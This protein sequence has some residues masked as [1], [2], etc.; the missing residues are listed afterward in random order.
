[1]FSL[2]TTH[3]PTRWFTQRVI[4]GLDETFDRESRLRRKNEVIGA[5]CSSIYF[6]GDKRVVTLTQP[7]WSFDY[8]SSVTVNP[9][10]SINSVTSV[11]IQ[12]YNKQRLTTES[13][14]RGFATSPL[15]TVGA[16]GQTDASEEWLENTTLGVYAQQQ[17]GWRGRVYVTGAV[18]ADDSSAFGDDFSWAIYPKFSA[19]WVMHEEPFWGLDWVSQFRLRGAWGAAG[20]QPDLIAASRL[21][22]P[23]TGTGGTPAV[24][25]LSFGNPDLGPERGEELELG[26]DAEFLDGR[27]SATF[28]RYW[29]STKDGILATPLPP[30][31]GFTSA[32]S[33]DVGGSEYFVNLGEVSGWGTETTVS[34]VAMA[35]DPLRWDVNFSFTT[36]GNEIKSLGDVDQIPVPRG[37]DHVVGYQLA[38]LFEKKVLRAEF[39]SG[40]SGAVTNL[41]CDGGVEVSG[42]ALPMQGGSAVPCDEAPEVFWGVGEPTRLASL[43]S[44]WTLFRDWQLSMLMDYKGGHWSLHEYLALKATSYP[45]NMNA[46]LEDNPVGMAY[47]NQIHRNGIA[48]TRAGFARLREVQLSYTF[49][50][51][52]AARIRADRV[53]VH[54]GMSNVATLWQAQS[55][56]EREPL[57][58]L[59][60]NSSNENF[61]GETRGQ[62]QFRQITMGAN[63]SF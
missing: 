6:D 46:Y 11:G 1:M 14:G 20:Q 58:D 37:R 39:E 22:Q 41:W 48:M 35:G 57:L 5:C 15:T 34:W 21:Y 45:A 42:K 52:L 2:T 36:M 53:R 49:P 24:I 10:P 32:Q 7:T 13:Y 29:R 17:I 12:Y 31:L 61:G 27:L 44:T 30:S 28:T 9:T 56:V 3:I 50:A 40:T 51:S 23:T 38:S 16:A 43:Q 60:S 19:T 62:L 63:V 47:V 59:D 55:H 33:I 26:F 8:S 4:V 25:P 54:A 18:R